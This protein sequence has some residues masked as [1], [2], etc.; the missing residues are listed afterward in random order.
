MKEFCVTS[1]SRYRH[2]VHTI[3]ANMSQT[4][5]CRKIMFR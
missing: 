4:V 1:C 2:A 3:Q 5:S